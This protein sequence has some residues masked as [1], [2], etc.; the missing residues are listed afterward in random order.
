MTPKKADAARVLVTPD[1]LTPNPFP[2]GKEDQIYLSESEM[3][4]LPF[5]DLYLVTGCRGHPCR[6]SLKP[7][8][9]FIL[10]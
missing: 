4:A 7:A 9:G 5:C 8:E 10:D 1:N 2:S 6:G 3:A